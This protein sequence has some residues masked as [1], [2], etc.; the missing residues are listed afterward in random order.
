MPGP[1]ANR[2]SLAHQAELAAVAALVQQR[3]RRIAL[4]VDT[5]D[6][7]GWWRR[8]AQ[9]LL[10]L[11]AA[12]FA[13]SRATGSRYLRRHA[14]L[15]GATVEPVLA[16][17]STAR[18]ATALRVTGP[19]EFKRAI[20]AVA[21]G[22][23][24]H[25]MATTLAGSA[26]RLALAG[27]RDTVAATV[28]DSGV[29]VGWRRQT[30]GDPCFFCAMLAS[31]GS[32][33]KSGA[34]AGD[35]QFGG[36][37]YH[38]HD[39]CVAV[40]LYEREDE[41]PEVLA[42]QDAWRRVTAGRSG[43][44]A[45]REWRRWWEENRAELELER[46]E[47]TPIPPP[48]PQPRPLPAPAPEPEPERPMPRG[49]VRPEVVHVTGE[50]REPVMA[51]LDRQAG[52]APRAMGRLRGVHPSG[53][54]DAEHPNSMAYYTVAGEEQFNLHLNPRWFSP[55]TARTIEETARKSVSSGWLSPTG[56]DHPVQTI[57]AH[58]LGHHITRAMF[59]DSGI[60]DV[61]D[62]QRLL[63]TIRD[64]L[65]ILVDVEHTPGNPIST[66]GTL[67]SRLTLAVQGQP[68]VKRQVSQYAAGSGWELLAEV[69]QEYS[70]LGERAR[71]HI[72]AIGQVMQELA[73]EAS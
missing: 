2:L 29:I 44:A 72:R 39:Q 37:Q 22:D 28:R 8:V 48:A 31:R 66:A 64:Q 54:F 21:P 6:V 7:D 65:G 62:A 61:A 43:Q 4:S 20:R 71:P 53:D 60:I 18:A 1:A 47:P 59:T 27:E 24:R 40:P 15:E 36:T 42:L 46:R 70:T 26:Q 12:A 58:E 35:L 73:E 69:W 3:V 16:R 5:Q 33:Y 25:A 38:D 56:A 67:M 50:L 19:V 63:E 23:A 49:G 11:V 57:M 32:V 68:A 13:G 45:I 17:W 14:A 9:E 30:D 51:E 41:P 34:T 10:T 52:L 55:A